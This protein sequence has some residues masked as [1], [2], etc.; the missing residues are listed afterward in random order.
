MLPLGLEHSL[1]TGEHGGELRAH[2][3]EPHDDGELGTTSV[4]AGSSDAE[5]GSLL[6]RALAPTV[7]A[8]SLR[9]H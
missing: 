3:G 2:Q 6:T 9:R 4:G 1:G 8:P 7:P 5:E